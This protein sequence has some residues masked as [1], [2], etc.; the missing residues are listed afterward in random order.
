MGVIS[1]GAGLAIARG[2]PTITPMTITQ[3]MTTRDPSIRLDRDEQRVET[4]H[5]TAAPRPPMM[6][7]TRPSVAADARVRPAG[8]AEACGAFPGA[9]QASGLG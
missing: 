2:I 8:V 1:A 3:A 9:R 5:S 4:A 6:A 7:V